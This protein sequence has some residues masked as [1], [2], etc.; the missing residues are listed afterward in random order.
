M[1]EEYKNRDPIL[2]TSGD[3]VGFYPREYY[4]F[5]NFSSFSVEWRG[6]LWSTSE[7][8]YQASKFFENSPEI[9]EEIYNARSAHDAQKLAQKH[10]D[11]I[12]PGFHDRNLDVMEDI[13][14]HKLKQH[15]Y[16][17]HK[18]RQTGDR[19][20]VE[21]SPKDEF[22]GWGADRKGRNELGKIWMKLREELIS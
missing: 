16:I 10:K 14:G 2:E 18:L 4:V 22:W 12:D 5:D 13:C 9:T 7:H 1:K 3:I 19:K 6:R 21:D 20:I 17:Q 8:A 11:K 15:E